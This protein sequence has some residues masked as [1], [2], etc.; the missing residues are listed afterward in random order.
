MAAL[1]RGGLRDAVHRETGLPLREAAEMVDAVLEAVAERLVAGE[2]VKLHG[3]GT[4]SVRAKG[5]R[6]GR[7]PRTREAV[8][9]TPRRVVSFRPSAVLKERI[10]DRM[11]Q[12]P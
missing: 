10:A 9:I 1:T 4:F 8:P 7:N 3:L 5:P 11:A 6:M 2:T 12:R